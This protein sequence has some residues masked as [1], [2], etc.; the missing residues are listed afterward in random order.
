MKKNN[1]VMLKRPFNKKMALLLIILFLIL[2]T[3]FA[4]WQLTLIQTSTNVVTTACFKLNFNEKD[5]INLENAYPISDEEAKQLIPYI[6]TIENICSTTAYYQINLEELETELKKLD[7]RYIKVS[8]NN[9]KGKILNTYTEVSPTLNDATISHKLTSG[10][11]RNNEIKTY[12]LRLW[13]DENTLATDEVMNAIIKSKITVIAVH[14]EDVEN[15]LR[16]ESRSLNETFSKVEETFEFK[17]ISKDYDIIEYSEDN[18]TYHPI[19][20]QGKEVIK[21][22]T[23]KKDGTYTMYFKDEVGNVVESTIETTKLDQDIPIVNASVTEQQDGILINASKSSDVKSGIKTYYYK[24]DQNEY[25]ESTSFNKIFTGLS[26]GSYE[27]TIKIEDNALNMSEEKVFKVVVAYQRVYISSTGNDITGVGSEDNPYATLQRGYDKVKSGG[28]ILLLSDLIVNSTTNMTITDKKVILKSNGEN[29]YSV[30]RATNFTLGVLNVTNVNNVTLEN[31]KFD[32][33]NVSSTF[34]LIFIDNSILNLAANVSLTKN[35]LH[36]VSNDFGGGAVFASN[37]STININ[38][39]SIMDNQ[40]LGKTNC[41]RGGGI[42]SIDSVLNIN[43][44][45]ISNNSVISGTNN[46]G[47]GIFVFRSTLNINDGSVSNNSVSNGTNN[48]GG[49]IFA[50]SSSVIM[51]GGSVSYNNVSTTSLS[52]GGGIWLSNGDFTMNGG[53]I[54]FNTANYG[55]G[56]WGLGNDGTTSVN[57]LGGAINKNTATRQGGGFGAEKMSTGTMIVTFKSSL[58]TDNI[59]PTAADINILDGVQVNY[60]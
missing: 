14:K 39:A 8:L 54:S 7:N 32:G 21:L 20:V 50:V 45:S 24:L 40:V 19:D 11:L 46:Q 49:G 16:I 56:F 18:I 57:I 17:G 22:R 48:Q 12:E 59:A 33:N 42:F 47:G 29:I 1:F 44:G 27:V 30:S 6:F 3:S 36:T 34:P 5:D 2:G 60:Q 38:G 52:G 4:L 37:N 9:S 28:E 58:I 23:Y 51:K 31:I 55:G 13:L 53:L 35:I 43:S 10:V 15:E 26:D 41:G 25:I